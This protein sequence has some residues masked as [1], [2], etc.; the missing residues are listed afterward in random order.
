MSL[1][2]NPW[3]STPS[4][5]TGIYYLAA[6]SASFIEHTHTFFA[7]FFFNRV[8]FAASRIAF[9]PRPVSMQK[10]STLF[11]AH[12]HTYTRPPFFY[13]STRLSFLFYRW[14]LGF[15]EPPSFRLALASLGVDRSREMTSPPLLNRAIANGHSIISSSENRST[16]ASFVS[17]G[18]FGTAFA[19]IQADEQWPRDCTRMDVWV[20][21]MLLPVRVPVRRWGVFGVVG[22]DSNRKK[23]KSNAS[24]RILKS[25]V[26][27]TFRGSI[28]VLFLIVNIFSIYSI[29][30]F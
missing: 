18:W 22:G 26:C 1:E 23:Y 2:P 21:S 25:S 13:F 19:F 11:L 12:T 28:W 4:H 10:S 15:S 5:Q 29:F 24:G 3:A 30:W 9:R 6:I 16:C 7:K 20:F 14:A 17:R 8:S 27:W